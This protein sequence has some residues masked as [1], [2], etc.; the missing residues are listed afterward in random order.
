[1]DCFFF[2]TLG[3]IFVNFGKSHQSVKFY[4]KK[5]QSIITTTQNHIHTKGIFD[6]DI[7][8]KNFEI[9]IDFVIKDTIN[10]HFYLISISLKN[11]NAFYCYSFVLHRVP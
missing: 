7:A 9:D 5:I 3:I 6:E 4:S 10:I 1:M 8:R 11:L 2:F